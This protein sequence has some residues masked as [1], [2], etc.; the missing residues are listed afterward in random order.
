MDWNWVVGDAKYYAV[1]FTALTA[2]VIGVAVVIGG[3]ERVLRKFGIGNNAS[4]T[5]R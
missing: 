1:A 5:A 3:V 4:E 2:Y